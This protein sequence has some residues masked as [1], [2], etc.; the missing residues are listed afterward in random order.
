MLP[1]LQAETLTFLDAMSIFEGLTKKQKNCVAEVWV[2]EHCCDGFAI[3][4]HPDIGQA[5]FSEVFEDKVQ[6]QLS[7]EAMATPIVDHGARLAL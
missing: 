7:E 6:V 2:A 1:C 3:P 5:T 4:W